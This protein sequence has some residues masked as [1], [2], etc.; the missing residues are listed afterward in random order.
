[1][2]CSRGCCNRTR[3][4]RGELPRKSAV[5][6]AAMKRPEFTTGM[7]PPVNSHHAEGARTGNKKLTVEVERSHKSYR[8]H[9]TYKTYIELPPNGTRT[10]TRDLLGSGDGFRAGR[11]ALAR[12]R[13]PGEI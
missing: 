3:L 2:R 10:P 13:Q 12:L 4:G 1:M 8:S 5:C 6:C 11:A 7:R 9:R